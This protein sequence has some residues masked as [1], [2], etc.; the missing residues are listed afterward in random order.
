MKIFWGDKF[1]WF[2]KNTKYLIDK[3]GGEEF[4]RRWT[5]AMKEID[6]KE[7]LKKIIKISQRGRK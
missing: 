4:I 3:Y 5:K 7:K 1:D 6:R 2:V